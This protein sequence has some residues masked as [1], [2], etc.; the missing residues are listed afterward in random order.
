MPNTFTQITIHLIFSVKNRNALITKSFREQLHKY[1]TGIITNQKQKLLAINAMPD[2]IHILIGLSPSTSLSD[3]VREIKSESSR[4]INENK[5]S[6]IKFNWQEG[7][8][9]FSY[10]R[11][12]RDNV[13]NYILNQE[14]HH[15]KL[16]FK[17]EYLNILEKFEI[18][19]EEKYLFDFFY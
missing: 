14:K 4:H 5:L 11:S 19:Y 17:E 15:K 16:N 7:F 12:Q 9:A 13:I 6:E 10:S 8:G 1:I 3:L 18:E 2:H